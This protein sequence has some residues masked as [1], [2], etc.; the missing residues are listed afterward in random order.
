MSAQPV[1]VVTGVASGIGAGIASLLADRGA[2]VIGLDQ[3]VPPSA[4]EGWLMMDLRSPVSIRAAVE[5]LPDRVDALCNVAGVHPRSA[6]GNDIVR[7]NYLG[8]RLLT[9]SVVGRMAPGAAVVNMASAA[10]AG[11]R[12]R[13]RL[14]R[15]LVARASF[16]EGW[17]WLREHPVPRTEGYS[18]SKE[19]LIVW[20][21]LTAVAWLRRGVRMNALAPGP[22]ETPA[23]AAFREAL[24]DAPNPDVDRIGRPGRIDEVARVAAFLCGV[25]SGWIN[26]AVIPADGGLT[27]AHL[28]DG[29]AP[30]RL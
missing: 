28:A 29:T 13:L 21:L 10:G 3:A 17:A 11:W 16:D 18:Y 8:T 30:A 1:V 14:H 12:S 26:G 23:F 9:E 15:E 19:A 27:A 24:G 25:E 7:A 6:D 2:T 22:V 4:R 20:T 5:R